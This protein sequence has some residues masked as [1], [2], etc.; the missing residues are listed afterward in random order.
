M[1]IPELSTYDPYYLDHPDLRTGK[2][3]TVITLPCFLGTILQPATASELKKELNQHFK[4]AHPGLDSTITL[5]HIRGLKASLCKIGVARDLEPSSVAFAHVY[6]EKLI[7]K[8][9]VNKI[10]KKL[11]ASC[12]LLLAVKVRLIKY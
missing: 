2:N 7:L 6:L 8:N 9:V 11:I 4:E 12:C 3:K 1:P 5:S 10:N